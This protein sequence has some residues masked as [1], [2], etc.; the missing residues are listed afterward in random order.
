MSIVVEDPSRVAA[1]RQIAAR[2]REL[3]KT[4]ELDQALS[5]F[6]PQGADQG[7]FYD[8]AVTRG[9]LDLKNRDLRRALDEREGELGLAITGKNSD[10]RK[11]GLK[12][13]LK[14]DPEYQG[15][16]TEIAEVD[17]QKVEVDARLEQLRYSLR[18]VEAKAQLAAVQIAVLGG[19]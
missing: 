19:N 12:N 4:P 13:A 15:L 7:P 1:S 16:L 17:Q 10:E 9:A 6:I 11:A 8:L 3:Y 2:I 18:A 5:Q 14:N